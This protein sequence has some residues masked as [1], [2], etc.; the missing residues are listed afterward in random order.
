[1]SGLLIVTHK[2]KDYRTWK[3][4]FD[5]T[6]ELRQHYGLRNGWV[7]RNPEDPN[8]LTVVFLCDDMNRARQFTTLPQL[9]EAMKRGGVEGEPKIC[10]LEQIAEVKAPLTFTG[11]C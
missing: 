7:A 8:L 4:V 10:L 1:M 6:E 11:R 9:R 2:V 5:E 3:P